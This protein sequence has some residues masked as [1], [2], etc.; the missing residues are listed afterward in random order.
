MFTF[1]RHQ[2]NANWKDTR[3][4]CP[5]IPVLLCQLRCDA[6][7]LDHW[8][9]CKLAGVGLRLSSCSYVEWGWSVASDEIIHVKCYRPHRYSL[10]AEVNSCGVV[11]DFRE[12]ETEIG[13]RPKGIV[14]GG[15]RRGATPVCLLDL[16]LLERKFMCIC[17]GGGNCWALWWM[18]CSGWISTRQPLDNRPPPTFPNQGDVPSCRST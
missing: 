16:W 3:A 13:A 11:S 6:W 1:N 8:P 14:H 18:T 5:N 10:Q 2:R 7:T 9:L 4:Y 17:S 15:N 12:L